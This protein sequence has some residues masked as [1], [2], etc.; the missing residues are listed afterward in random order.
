[1][2]LRWGEKIIA[3]AVIANGL[4]LN[5]REWDNRYIIAKI[6]AAGGVDARLGNIGPLATDANQISH[7]IMTPGLVYVI[8]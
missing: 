8:E 3:F 1:M 4:K 6:S 2:W 7:G 5:F